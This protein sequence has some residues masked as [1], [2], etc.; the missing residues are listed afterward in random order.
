MDELER[1]RLYQQCDQILVDDAAFIGCDYD[2]YIRLL[3]LNVRN[4]PQNAME[5]RDLSQVFLSKEKTK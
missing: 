1:E 5:Y 3:G 2:E 4:F